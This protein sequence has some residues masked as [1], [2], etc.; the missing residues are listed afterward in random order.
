MMV[1]IL[2]GCSKKITVEQAD[3][4]IK[5][6][7][8]EAEMDSYKRSLQLSKEGLKQTSSSIL[9]KD[10]NPPK[11]NLGDLTVFLEANDCTE[12]YNQERALDACY[13]LTRALLINTT[14][15]LDYISNQNWVRGRAINQLNENIDAIIDNFAN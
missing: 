3:L 5:V 13:Q 9:E 8:M 4:Y 14:N 1:M 2:S 6:K 7:L 12:V 11:S 10:I 15:K